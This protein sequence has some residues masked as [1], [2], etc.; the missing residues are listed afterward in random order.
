MIVKL[1]SNRFM[2]KIELYLYSCQQFSPSIWVFLKCF[3]NGKEI[4]VI[5]NTLSKF[6]ASIRNKQMI[7][8]I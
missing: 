3:F 2:K 8:F 7:G 1:L 5:Q 6:T 4:F